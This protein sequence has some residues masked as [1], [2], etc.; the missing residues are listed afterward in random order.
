MWFGYIQLIFFS[1]GFGISIFVFPYVYGLAL[2]KQT[3]IENI[4]VL[5]WCLFNFS[6][7]NYNN[8]YR[9]T[10]HNII[11]LTSIITRFQRTSSIYKYRWYCSAGHRYRS[12]D[13][14]FY[15]KSICIVSWLSLHSR[16]YLLVGYV[17][18]DN[19][20]VYINC[21]NYIFTAEQFHT[22]SVY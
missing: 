3:N 19:Y 14:Y 10:F 18:R 20:K 13:Y 7:Y 17:C 2:F 12:D 21:I 5:K 4:D 16:L 6:S 8:I 1:S 11:H 15:R 9:L 22:T